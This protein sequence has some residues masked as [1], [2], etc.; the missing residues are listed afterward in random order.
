MIREETV[1]VAAAAA[2]N[3]WQ[4]LPDTEQQL[5]QKQLTVAEQRLIKGS[6]IHNFIGMLASLSWNTKSELFLNYSHVTG[7][8][9]SRALKFTALLG[10]Y[11]IVNYF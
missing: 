10:C 5:P 2:P 3:A 8:A 11:P 1:T 4:Q 7:I 9:S 6:E